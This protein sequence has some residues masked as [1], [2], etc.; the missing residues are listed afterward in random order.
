MRWHASEMPPLED[1]VLSRLHPH[2]G[3][4]RVTADLSVR[5]ITVREVI[6]P[7]GQRVIEIATEGEPSVWDVLGMLDYAAEVARQQIREDLP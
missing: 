5:E 4:L 1:Q 3:G 7:E 2:G 6:S